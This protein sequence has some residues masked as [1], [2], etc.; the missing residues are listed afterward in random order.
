MKYLQEYCK[1][2]TSE[3]FLD[4]IESVLTE[5]LVQVFSCQFIVRS[6]GHIH[7]DRG[8]HFDGCVHMFP[9]PWG[10]LKQRF[11]IACTKTKNTDCLVSF[12][13]M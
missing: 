3:F 9:V 11:H 1:G 2:I 13:D 4:K 12:E 7:S 6:E 5:K 8:I 10:Q